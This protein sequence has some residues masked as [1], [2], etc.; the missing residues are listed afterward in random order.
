MSAYHPV[1]GGYA[2]DPM[3]SN[4]RPPLATAPTAPSDAAPEE[5]QPDQAPLDLIDEASM[6]SFPCSDPP[7]YTR[8]HA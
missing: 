4:P 5:R 3:D 8:C 6:E 7:S 2:S 1:A